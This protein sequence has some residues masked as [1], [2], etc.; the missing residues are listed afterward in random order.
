[1]KHLIPSFIN[2]DVIPCRFVLALGIF[3]ITGCQINKTETGCLDP[4]FSTRNSAL[5]TT[6]FHRLESPPSDNRDREKRVQAY[7][8]ESCRSVT[9]QEIGSHEGNNLI[10]LIPGNK[11]SKFVIGAHYDKTGQGDGVADNWSGIVLIARLAAELSDRP[12]NFSWELIAFGAEESGLQGS[13][14]YFRKAAEAGNILAMINVDTLGL[15]K[16][17]IDSR[18]D[19]YLDCL[20]SELAG[21]MNMEISDARMNQTTGD[22]ETFSHKGISVLNLHSL[23]R[24]SIKKV[25]TRKDRRRAISDNY[26]EDAWQLLDNL[27]HYLDQDLAKGRLTN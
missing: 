1:L 21:K 15:G 19:E 9:K 23:N 12:Q 26:L 20:A 18:S 22:W 13:K 8:E 3:V 5:S 27:Q 7:F 11:G 10:C 4:S 16:V 25:H 2:V 24:Q 14:T 6:D 17:N